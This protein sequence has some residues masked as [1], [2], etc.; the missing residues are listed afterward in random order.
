MTKIKDFFKIEE[1]Y[2]FEINDFR[3]IIQILNVVLILAF[4]YRFAWL[5]LAV[6]VS[7]LIKDFKTDRHING[8]GMHS[9]NIILNIYFIFFA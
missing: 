4:G 9:A 5:G 7:G 6:A 1:K 2:R 8:I 3:S